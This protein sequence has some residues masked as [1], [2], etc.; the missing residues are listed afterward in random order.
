M[1]DWLTRA[2]ETLFGQGT[3]IITPE[4]TSYE[5]H[6]PSVMG[7][8]KRGVG[9][10]VEGLRGYKAP[11]GKIDIPQPEEPKVQ[12]QPASEQYASPQPQDVEEQMRKVLTDYGGEDLPAMDYIPL[13]MEAM[14]MYPMFAQNPYL[15]PQM[16]I[17]ESSGG[18]NVTRP[19]NPLNWGARVQA[20]GGFSP[21]SF[22]E[23]IMKAITG[24]GER[25]DYYEPFRQDRPLTDEEIMA[26]AQVY[27]PANAGY[28][29]NLLEG[30]K[31]FQN[32]Q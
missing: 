24:M 26:F 20:E 6:R 13:F 7:T 22:E 10:A 16:S 30:I 25:F 15:L 18:Q 9:R 11:K 32:F 1:N 27:E 8:M 3:D 19:N 31:H 14:K 21:E 4:G 2:F 17:L 5:E 28:G 12:P 29:G 23:S